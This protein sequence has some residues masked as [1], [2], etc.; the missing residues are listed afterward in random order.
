MTADEASSGRP[1][2]RRDDA[3]VLDRDPSESTTRRRG[4]APALVGIG[5][6]A[7]VEALPSERDR[8]ILIASD[9]RWPRRSSSRSRTWPRTRR[10][11]SA[12]ASSPTARVSRASG[13]PADPRAR[14]SHR[15]RPR[16]PGSA[17]G[18]TAAVAAGSTARDRRIARRCA[19]R[20]P[21]R[22]AWAG[23]RSALVGV[24]HPGRPSRPSSGTCVGC[25]G[26]RGR[27][28]ATSTIRAD[29]RSWQRTLAD[30]ETRLIPALPRLRRSLIH[31]DANDHNVL[32]D[33][34]GA[35]ASSAC[36]T[37]AT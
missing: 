29:G 24:D 12:R 23:S 37:S 3:V 32:V 25:R 2:P 5:Q 4:G 6:R 35:S 14:R 9:G 10:S 26:H 1:R 20:R 28:S 34:A 19:P 7:A 31:N 21:R 36:S 8:N 17:V 27:T 16:R 33:D 30:L 13:R 11:S 22:A 18:A 15:R